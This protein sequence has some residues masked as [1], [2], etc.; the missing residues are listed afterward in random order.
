[1][2][3]TQQSFTSFSSSVD[4]AIPKW[5]LGCSRESRESE[6][7][8][9]IEIEGMQRRSNANACPFADEMAAAGSQL[10][11]RQQHIRSYHSL[12]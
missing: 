11:A 10:H 9:E 8:T 6:L 5:D 12:P 1:M 3:C 7:E 4:A 2:P